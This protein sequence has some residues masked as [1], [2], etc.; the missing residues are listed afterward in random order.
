MLLTL[1]FFLS[2]RKKFLG[3]EIPEKTT[4]IDFDY[5]KTENIP[6]VRRPTGGRAILHDMRLLSKSLYSHFF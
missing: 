2:G 5:L 6:L 3:G 4:E 1:C